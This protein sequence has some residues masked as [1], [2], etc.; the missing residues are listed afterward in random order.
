ML[1]W[2]SVSR[3]YLR[4]RGPMISGVKHPTTSS[5]SRQVQSQNLL[6]DEYHYEEEQTVEDAKQLGRAERAST[7]TRLR[8]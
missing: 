4:R 6:S 8:R 1:E 2:L 5:L 3:R 7:Y